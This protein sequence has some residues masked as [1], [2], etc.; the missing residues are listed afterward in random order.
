MKGD[1]CVVCGL[2]QDDDNHHCDPKRLESINRRH[3]MEARRNAEGIF[4][5]IQGHSFGERLRDGFRMIHQ[6]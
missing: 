5:P 4:A 6:H 3:D 2:N 1:T